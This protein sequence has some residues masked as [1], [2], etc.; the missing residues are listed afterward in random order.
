MSDFPEKVIC[1]YPVSSLAPMEVC[2]EL[3]WPDLQQAEFIRRDIHESRISDLLEANNCYLERARAAENQ[4]EEDADAIVALSVCCKVR[5]TKNNYYVIKKTLE[6]N[7][8]V[9]DRAVAKIAAR[10]EKM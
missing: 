1:Y 3:G 10:K 5:M 8:A 6:K 9:I 2:T 7:K 4:I